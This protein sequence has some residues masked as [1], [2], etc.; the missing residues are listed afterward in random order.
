MRRTVLIFL[1]LAATAL[2]AE[3]LNEINER[4]NSLRERKAWA[5]AED[6]FV[7]GIAEHP[8]AEWLYTNL[9][10]AL[11]EQK[12]TAAAIDIAE[13]A[14]ARF[15]NSDRSRNALALGLMQRADQLA[16]AGKPDAALADSKRA[17]DL[18]PTVNYVILNYALALD[19]SQK[20]SEAIAVYR[21]GLQLH[22][23]YELLK[24][25]MVWTFVRNA[26][27]FWDAGDESG[28]ALDLARE[29]YT[30]DPTHQGAAQIYGQALLRQQDALGAIAV[31]SS[32]HAKFTDSRAFCWPLSEAYR[33]R[34]E[35][36]ARGKTEDA[37]ARSA[38]LK[39][40]RE[41]PKQLRGEPV[42]DNSLLFA[43]D[44]SYAL[45]SA[46]DEAI[47]L[48]ESLAGK[49]KNHAIYAEHAGR[50]MNRYAVWLRT[51]KRDASAAT[52]MRD[53]ANVWLRRAMDVYEKNHPDRP[54][55][56]GPVKF[57]LDGTTLVV[58]SFDSGGTHS[59]FG[60]Y[61]YDLVTADERGST[62]RPNRTGDANED[63][64]G[65]GA[66]VYAAR[67]GVVDVTDDGDPDAQPNAVQYQ[68]D[69]NYVRVRHTDGTF[70][71]YVHLKNGSV[72]VKVGQAVRAGEQLGALGNSGMSVSPHLHFCLITDDYV[73]LDFRF[74][75]LNL[76]RAVGAPT[77][78]TTDP[79]ESGWLVWR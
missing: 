8:E 39:V 45:L 60:K 5:E 22:R 20:Y 30:I 56:A 43:F 25:N 72:R 41:I 66:P 4:W 76:R 40:A 54:R 18:Q 52:A 75:K 73:S 63:F 9:A 62:V 70:G 74:V 23:D 19:R 59:G 65:F 37:S 10:W 48:F 3:S 57:P 14:V 26:Q 53:R 77:E 13:R 47:P 42:C 15:D 16:N 2:T 58:A 61:C 44:Q 55:V 31:L 35:Q 27:A 71:W 29:A 64:Y 51:V 79:L 7:A 1:L 36:L 50:H 69:G 12:K 68:T 24:R 78:T 49:Y 38:G 17:Y 28:Q 67:D 6:M 32:A 34:V 11:R 21:A 33:L 46:F